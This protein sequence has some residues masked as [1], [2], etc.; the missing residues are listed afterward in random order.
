MIVM[1]LDHTR[2]FFHSTAMTADP[3]DPS[4]TTVALFF[5]RWI[6][7]FCAP[8]FVFLSGLSAYLSLQK[9]PSGE[10]SLFLIKRGIWL[11]VAEVTIVTLGLTFNPSYNIIILQ[12]IWAIGWSMVILGLL[13]RISYTVVLVT[14]LFLVLAH[15]A[16]DYARLPAEGADS[17]L[18]TVLLTS[19]G[20]AYP[21]SATHVVY[22]FYAILPWTGIMLIGYSI[23]PWFKKDFSAGRRK[24]LLL[25]SGSALVALFVVLR[26]SRGYGDPG[27]WKPGENS[28]F[29]FLDT[30]KYPP[31][32]QYCCMTLGPALLLLAS[33][34]AI[35]SGWTRIVT[36]YGRVPFFYYILHFYLL[37][38]L[39][40]IVF[41]ATGHTSS[42]IIDPQSIFAFRP[43]N[44]GFPLSVVY[45]IWL[46]VV[47]VLYFPCKWFNNYKEGHRQWWLKYI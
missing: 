17:I 15:N 7:H 23:A 43:V 10:A 19:R 41:F 14:G 42:Q 13:I 16:L 9:K 5:T 11:V 25:M 26:F 28:F 3:L 12:V 35:R 33:L 21:L 30:S 45:F 4:T 37:H 31:S 1:A 36:V 40:V 20:A 34:E 29:S 24:Q 39:V 32:L 47:V 38:T 2:D 8:V 6:T 46:T 22:A 44:F 18:W 27:A